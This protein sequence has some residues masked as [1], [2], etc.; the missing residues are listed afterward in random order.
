MQ[1]NI[2]TVFE[3]SPL[4]QYKSL[5]TLFCRDFSYRYLY[6]SLWYRQTDQFHNCHS[7]PTNMVI[8]QSQFHF[9][10]FLYHPCI[11]FLNSHTVNILKRESQLIG[12]RSLSFYMYMYVL[13]GI[14]TMM[15][16]ILQNKSFNRLFACYLIIYRCVLRGMK[17]KYILLT[18]FPTKLVNLF[19]NFK[20]ESFRLPHKVALFL[21]DNEKNYHRFL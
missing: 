14:N 13:Q 17:Y 19:Q 18:K 9:K 3:H 1:S 16:N 6:L 8:C 4:F 15:N 7:F 11:A 20:Y 5:F 10:S 2:T 12:F 21:H